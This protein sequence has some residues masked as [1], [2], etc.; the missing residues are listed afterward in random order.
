MNGPIRLILYERSG[1]HLCDE[2]RGMLDRLIGSERYRRLDIDSE[3]DLVVRYGFRVPVISLDGVDR[4]E[5]PIL[6]SDLR[7][8]LAELD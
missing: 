8:L 6:E 2:V 5:A 7:S 3:D 1:C 4:L